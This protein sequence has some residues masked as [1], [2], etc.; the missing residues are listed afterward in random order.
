LLFFL[1]FFVVLDYCV[2]VFVIYLHL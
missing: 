2:D 1:G